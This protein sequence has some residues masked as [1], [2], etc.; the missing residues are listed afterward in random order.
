[1]DAL[2]LP[3]GQT[4]GIKDIQSKFCYLVPMEQ[5]NADIVVDE[6]RRWFCTYVMP[7]LIVTDNASYFKKVRILILEQF[8][9]LFWHLSLPYSP[10]GH[11]SIEN[12]H[13]QTLKNLR[14]TIKRKD[15]VQVIDGNWFYLHRGY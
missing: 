7:S 13:S 1:L 12:L 14:A 11:G 8:P 6:L 5:V 3:G 15:L 10:T 2:D 9:K 4:L